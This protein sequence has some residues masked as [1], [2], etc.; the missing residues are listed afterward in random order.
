MKN[1]LVLATW[2]IFGLT[3]LATWQYSGVHRKDANPFDVEAAKTYALSEHQLA[4]NEEKSLL[5]ERV[6]S[7][8]KDLQK[9]QQKGISKNF[10][11]QFTSEPINSVDVSEVDEH[12]G[13]G[14]GERDQFDDSVLRRS[15][16]DIHA[17]LQGIYNTGGS[18]SYIRRSPSHVPKRP[19]LPPPVKVYQEKDEGSKRPEEDDKLT[20]VAGSGGSKKTAMYSNMYRNGFTGAFFM[21]K[22]KYRGEAKGS[23]VRVAKYMFQCLD[24]KPPR[25]CDLAAAKRDPPRGRGWQRVARIS[26]EFLELLP[27]HDIVQDLPAYKTCAV[28]GNGGSLLLN[29]LGA[30]IDAHDAVIRFNGGITKGFEKHVGSRTTFRLAN[31]Q[32]MGF[33]EK[34]DE[35]IFQHITIEGSLDKMSLVK[36]KFPKLQIYAF[37]GDF[38]QYVLDTVDDGAASNGFFGMVFAF[39]NCAYVTLYGFHKSW[40]K[41][42]I[43]GGGLDKTKYHYYDNVEPNESQERRDNAETPRLM[44]F[45]A[46]HTDKFSFA[47]FELNKQVRAMAAEASS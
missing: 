2:A 4:W 38:H 40:K 16:E 26:K 39:E 44:K 6:L 14:N 46:K 9:G 24:P 35:I 17:E 43:E 25:G 41:G 10:R 12:S 33:H 20:K 13:E 34:E 30:D 22:E 42:D 37:D 47:D 1:I 21:N 23:P 31:T 27:E 3:L 5:R 7:L 29:T 8:E 18:A 15:K 32:H 36:K 45:I 11:E 19:P 28:V